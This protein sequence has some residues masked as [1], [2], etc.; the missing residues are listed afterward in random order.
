MDMYSDLDY[1]DEVDIR[2]KDICKEILD[3]NSGEHVIKKVFEM[4]EL[5]CNTLEITTHSDG[6][7]NIKLRKLFLLQ[8]EDEEKEPSELIKNIFDNLY[9]DK[10]LLTL[11]Y[12]NSFPQSVIT[13][14]Y[15]NFS[16]DEDCGCGYGSQD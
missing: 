11:I 12:K 9:E 4:V 6:F 2:L 15:T 5:I 1:N 7:K 16:D 8:D 10:T 14:D 13:A 3:E